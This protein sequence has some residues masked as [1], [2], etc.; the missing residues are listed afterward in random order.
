MAGKR[1]KYLWSHDSGITCDYPIQAF[2]RALTSRGVGHLKNAAAPL[3]CAARVLSKLKLS[4][5]K[6]QRIFADNARELYG[7]P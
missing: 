7:L 6:L 2:Q 3:R 4:K 5:D 1:L